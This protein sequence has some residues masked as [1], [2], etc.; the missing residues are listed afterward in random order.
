MDFIWHHADVVLQ[1][2]RD[3]W[4]RNPYH[5]VVEVLFLVFLAYFVPQKVYFQRMS[6][7]NMVRE[8]L[9]EKEIDELCAEWAPEPLVPEKEARLV[10]HE[11]TEN[12]HLVDSIRPGRLTVNGV[13]CLDLATSNF[14]GF[15]GDAKI[16][17]ACEHTIRTNGVGTCGPRGFYGTLDKHLTLEE[18]LAAFFGVESSILYSYDFASVTSA[19]CAFAKR[20]DFLVMDK[21]A[22]MSLQSSCYL[23]RAT[24]LEYEHNDMGSLESLLQSVVSKLTAHQELVYRKFIVVEGVYANVGDLCNIPEVLRLAKKYRFRIIMD[25][26]L[27]MGTLG[28]TGR[29][30]TE[31]FGIAPKEID[32]LLGSLGHSFASV[33]GFCLGSELVCDHQRLSGVGYCFSASQPTYLATAALEA[34]HCIERDEDGR[35]E[36]LSKNVAAAY[37]ELEKFQSLFEVRGEKT[38][39]APTVAPLIHVELVGAS[40]LADDAAREALYVSVME[41]MLRKHKTALSLGRFSSIS[42]AHP[43]PQS[44]KLAVNAI[45]SE[46]QIRRAVRALAQVAAARLRGGYESDRSVGQL[47]SSPAKAHLLG[48]PGPMTRR[49][50]QLVTD[51][52]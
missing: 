19:I 23:S 35:L 32:I 47:E 51:E 39:A 34:L 15:A 48:S 31:H 36:R 5:I 38:T 25:D 29:G 8:Q 2:L 45:L 41:D 22:N 4:A 21:A 6:L 16:L 24:V 17:Q 18:S 30:T 27:G 46:D 43:L 28:R 42:E 13:E 44:L 50:R 26:A 14:L 40:A 1:F 52:A 3:E 9:T 33:G 20:G 7:R 10:A 12:P 37:D 49:R 11:A